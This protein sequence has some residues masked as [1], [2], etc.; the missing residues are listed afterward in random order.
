MAS[1]ELER[2]RNLQKTVNQQKKDRE[3][4]ARLKA[5]FEPSFFDVAKKIIKKL[6]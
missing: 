6:F 3:E 2:L 5:E 1:D 4:Q